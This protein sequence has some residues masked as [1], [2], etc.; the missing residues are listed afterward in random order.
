MFPRSISIELAKWAKMDK[1]KP[2]VLRGAR[3]VGKTTVIKVFGSKFDV[4]IYLN[5]EISAERNLFERDLPIAQLIQ[6]IFL[7]KNVSRTNQQTLLIFIDEIQNSP[8]AVAM[9]RYFYEEYPDIYVIAAGSLLESLIDHHLSFPVGRVEYKY[10]FPLTFEEFLS[11]LQEEKA[12]EL[13]QD[14]A[15]PEYAHERLLE[16]FHLYTMIGGMPEVVASFAQDREWMKLMPIYTSLLLGYQEDAEKYAESKEQARVIRH[17]IEQAPLHAGSRIKFQNFGRSNYRS[18][19]ISE[20]MRIL[21]KALLIKLVY[22]TTALKPPF[23]QNYKKSPR[24]QFLDTGIVNFSLG[25]HKE[26]FSLKDLNN[27]YQGKIVEHIVGQEL[28]GSKTVGMNQLMFWVR[29]KTQSSAEVDYV[30]GN[31]LQLIPIEVKSGKTGTLRS[32]Y[33]FIDHSSNVFAIRLYSGKS[34]QEEVSTLLGKTFKLLHLP[35]YLS[36]QLPRY[37]PTT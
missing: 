20:A 22:P 16:L 19:E 2:L 7:H 14:Q 35:Y 33:S 10:L 25:L 9:L 36:G 11:A 18:R 15:I 6:S 17:I 1:H 23:E 12:L 21:E 24:L 13:L 4:F 31:G 34:K 5:L 3:Q 32:L 8:A 28:L 30:I 27:L 26:F 29:E 37:Y